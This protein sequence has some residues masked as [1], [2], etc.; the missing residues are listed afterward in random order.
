[1]IRSRTGPVPVGRAVVVLRDV[2]ERVQ[3]GM[4]VGVLVLRVPEVMGIPHLG[5]LDPDAGLGRLGADVLRPVLR[6]LGRFVR[7]VVYAVE[8]VAARQRQR[9]QLVDV[10]V[11]ITEHESVVL[12]RRD[13]AEEGALPLAGVGIDPLDEAA[14]PVRVVHVVLRV[15]RIVLPRLAGEVKAIP[16]LDLEDDVALG[17]EPEEA[18]EAA[19]ILLARPVQIVQA[20]G[21]IALKRPH[22]PFVAAGHRATNVVAADRHEQI[23]VPL[24]VRDLKQVVLDRSA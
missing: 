20:G 10:S 13:G 19:P 17:G 11:L 22:V 9:E 6:P 16:H 2:Y 3:L 8:H 15:E 14:L 4:A 12:Q 23:E 24:D 21:R 5:D 1:M 18:V 7:L